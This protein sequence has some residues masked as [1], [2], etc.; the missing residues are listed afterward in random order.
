MRRVQDLRD[1]TAPAARITSPAPRATKV[2]PPLEGDAVP[3]PLDQPLNVD[4]G[5][6]PQVRALQT[7]LRKATGPRSSG[8]PRF[9]FTWT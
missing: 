3:A 2:P 4:A 9:W 7:G 6:E 1:A 5:L 8:R